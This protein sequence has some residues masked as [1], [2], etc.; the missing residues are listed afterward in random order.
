MDPER[1]S[2][3]RP[4]WTQALGLT[5]P[6]VRLSAAPA[7]GLNAQWRS[8]TPG[9]CPLLQDLLRVAPTDMAD[10]IGAASSGPRMLAP[11]RQRQFGF[12]NC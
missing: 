4:Q 9:R 3:T 8:S 11:G 2:W 12:S 5:T 6:P 10:R 7:F 1:S